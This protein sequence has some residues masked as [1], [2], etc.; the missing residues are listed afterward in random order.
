MQLPKHEGIEKFHERNRTYDPKG[1][2]R[3]EILYPDSFVFVGNCYWF[4]LKFE[5][6]KI[7]FIGNIVELKFN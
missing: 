3:S 5:V 2:I 7:L 4:M 1:S 6:Y